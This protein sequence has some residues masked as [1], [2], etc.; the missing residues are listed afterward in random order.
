MKLFVTRSQNCS[1]GL[2]GFIKIRSILG[3][4]V[5]IKQEH[6][7]AFYFGEN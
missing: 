2:K 5:S 3:C 7:N 4:S 6:I 1:I